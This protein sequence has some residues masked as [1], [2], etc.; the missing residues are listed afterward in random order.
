MDTAQNWLYASPL[1]M[2]LRASPYTV[3]STKI[4]GLTYGC[5]ARLPLYWLLYQV[6][7]IK[8]DPR[9]LVYPGMASTEVNRV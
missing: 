2:A 3:R 4:D 1:T 5:R 8:A 9:A 7:V 6:E